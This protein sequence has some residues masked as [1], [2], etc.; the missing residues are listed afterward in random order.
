[1]PEP[2]HEL[3]FCGLMDDDEESDDFLDL[4]EASD[5]RDD[6]ENEDDQDDED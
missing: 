4:D 5:E 2:E 3:C 6:A 1:M